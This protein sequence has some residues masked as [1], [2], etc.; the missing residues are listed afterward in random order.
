M[1]NIL[2]VTDDILLQ[3]AIEIISLKN[4]KVKSVK[5]TSNAKNAIEICGCNNIDIVIVDIQMYSNIAIDIIKTIKNAN[6]EISIFALSEFCTGSY[7]WRELKDFI[8]DII[9]KPITKTK[10]DK[11]IN[12]Y[13]VESDNVAKFQLDELL[14][15]LNS[16]DFKELY[17]NIP[18]LNND[19]YGENIKDSKTLVD[20]FTNI[21]NKVME[22][23][24]Y[25]EDT[26]NIFELFPI[27]E[28]MI[29]DKKT[30]EIWLSQI[31]EYMFRKKCIHRYNLLENIF[32]YID[33]N[34]KN[35]ITLNEITDSCSISQGYLSRIFREQLNV[36][37]MDYIHIK[38]IYLAKVYFYFTTD[39]IAEVAFK[40]G[41]N[42]SSYFSKVFKKYE[43]VTVKQYKKDNKLEK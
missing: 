18:R 36:S 19:I 6:P 30:G 26:E 3:K 5:T 16:N 15:L 12:M 34:I 27:N 28:V 20:I 11:I 43:N 33:N 13:K 39:S 29:S 17:N 7:I 31:M 24:S 8:N 4:N 10:V 2:A 35:K 41:Y 23:R 14:L 9:E 21:G 40:L 37:V 38:K 42:E 32:I 22:T 1:Q 25:H